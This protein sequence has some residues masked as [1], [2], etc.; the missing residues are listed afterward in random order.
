LAGT[1]EIETNLTE[2]ENPVVTM[3]QPPALFLDKTMYVF[4]GGADVIMLEGHFLV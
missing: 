3:K 1:Q 4:I 2:P